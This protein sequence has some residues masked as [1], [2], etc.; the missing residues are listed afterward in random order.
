M[1]KLGFHLPRTLS[2]AFS[3]HRDDDLPPFQV[4]NGTSNDEGLRRRVGGSRIAG[5]IL[6]QRVVLIGGSITQSTASSSGDSP[7]RS[8]PPIQLS[9]AATTAQGVP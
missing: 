3:S 4:Q 7:A 5:D 9:A 8:Q 2:Q 1:A 6:P